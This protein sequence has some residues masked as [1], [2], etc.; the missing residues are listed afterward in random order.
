MKLNKSAQMKN[1]WLIT[2]LFIIYS[3][4]VHAIEIDRICPRM[5]H[6]VFNGY[7]PKGNNI[8]QIIKRIS[9]YVIQNVE[10]N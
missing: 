6:R 7:A 4:V 8:N 9:T 5:L 3:V 1:Y 10:L 2:F